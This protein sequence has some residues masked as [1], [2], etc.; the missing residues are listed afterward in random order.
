MGELKSRGYHGLGKKVVL[1]DPNPPVYAAAAPL[2]H[3]RPVIPPPRPWDPP[4]TPQTRPPARVA[5]ATMQAAD[6]CYVSF[7]EVA[8]RQWQKRRS[9]LGRFTLPFCLCGATGS[10]GGWQCRPQTAIGHFQGGMG[11]IRARVPGRHTARSTGPPGARVTG[12]ARRRV[13]PAPPLSLQ[14][15]TLAA[16][17]GED[18]HPPAHAGRSDGAPRRPRNSV[19]RRTPK[20]GAKPT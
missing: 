3:V 1:G 14:A 9:L 7:P 18:R 16:G 11:G 2:V 5:G 17:H 20:V 10:R 8:V 12:T 15:S 4:S 13:L 6:Y 19:P